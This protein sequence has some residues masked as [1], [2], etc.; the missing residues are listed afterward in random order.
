MKKFFVLFFVSLQIFLSF[1]NESPVLQN[2]FPNNYQNFSSVESQEESLIIKECK[3]YINQTLKDFK[4][5]ED[6]KFTKVFSQNISDKKIYRIFLTATDFEKLDFPVLESGTYSENDFHWLQS[7]NHAL[8]Q[9]IVKKEADGFSPVSSDITGLW[10][11]DNGGTH[12]YFS[13]FL[14][15]QHEETFLTMHLKSKVPVATG[16]T[17]DGLT[18]V[19]FITRGAS[20]F[21]RQTLD[22]TL[23]ENQSK[24]KIT[25]DSSD[26]LAD[27][28]SPL[29]YSLL[30][31][32]DK[33]PAT[34]YKENS[35]ENVISLK[36]NFQM[37]ADW[38]RKH[39]KIKITQAS[40]INGDSFSRN[41]YFSCDRIG[42]VSAEAWENKTEEK[43]KETSSF[44]LKDYSL[45]A[46]KMFLPFTEGKNYY[47]FTTSEII[48]SDRHDLSISEFNLKLSNYGWFF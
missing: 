42:T 46:Q 18:K 28:K 19:N 36:I 8:V 16:S 23:E 4:I 9:I 31:A 15:F 20:L 37:A 14:I 26:F 22:C 2:I 34:C 13:D 12:I 30:S 43:T 17:W 48:K 7:P 1:A 29:K 27:K 24:S 35:S 41:E 45:D 21:G 32:F 5:A 44:V 39:G 33:N 11:H 47:I 3:N 10:Q 6:F 40:I 25:I 38:T